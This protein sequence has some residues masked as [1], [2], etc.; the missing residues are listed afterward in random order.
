[1][2]R[3]FRQPGFALPDLQIPA[4]RHAL[5]CEMFSFQRCRVHHAIV[6]AVRVC[7]FAVMLSLVPA[8]VFAQ[9]PAASLDPQELAL[10]DWYI[11]TVQLP[12][13]SPQQPKKQE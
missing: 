10:G 3:W 5:L 4:K 9:A 1:M 8:A 7:A 12:P 11:V 13:N 6:A 2:P